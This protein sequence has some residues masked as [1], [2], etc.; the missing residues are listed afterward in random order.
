MKEYDVYLFDFDGTLF[1]TRLSLRKVWRDAFGAIGQTVTDEECDRFMHHNLYE[2]LAFRHVE[3]KDYPAFGQAL[4]ESID[5]PD[6]VAQNIPFPETLSV[7]LSLAT[8]GKKIGLVSG[9]SAKHIRLVW[10]HWKFPKLTECF[11]GC[12]I[13]QKGK[14]DP[15][16]LNM[17]LSALGESS[18]S[19][20]VYIGDSFQDIEAADAAGMDSFFIDR[21][22]EYPD[23][24]RKKITSL[25]EVIPE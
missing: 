21:E 7:L 9:N 13:Y 14:P 11:M 15:E 12:D 23:Y 2:T 10:D 20:A 4:T 25:T 18:G 16:P 3:P 24:P 5:S 17:A 19:R 22:N 1:D 8:K 6:T